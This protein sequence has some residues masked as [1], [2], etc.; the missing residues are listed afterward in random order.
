MPKTA[1]DSWQLR[2]NVVDRGHGRGD[3]SPVFKLKL[4]RKDL[5]LAVAMAESL[6]L[7][8]ACAKGALAWYDKGHD[9]GHDDLD[10]NAIM[11]TTN[12]ELRRG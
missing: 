11:L 1:A 6:G 2:N 10:Q 7:P 3:F 8:N 12:P 5:Q 4:A 9:A